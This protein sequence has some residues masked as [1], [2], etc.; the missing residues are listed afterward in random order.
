MGTQNM[1]SMEDQSVS[2]VDIILDKTNLKRVDKTKFLG[3][4][5]D[6]NFSWKNHIDCI[7]K[8]I[9]RNIGMIDKLKFATPERILRTLY[10]TLVLPYINYGI[11]IWG[12]ACKT[13]LEKIHKLQKWA[14]R[15]LSNSYYHSH[16]APLFQKHDILDVYVSYKLEL[17]VFMYF[18]DLLS[19]SFNAFFTQLSDF[20][21]MTQETNLITIQLELKGFC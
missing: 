14:V 21:I 1:T 15:L 13:Y 16:S 18:N 7:T 11:P 19:M 12:K 3:V 6:K 5:I 9:S 10:C 17:G 8:T 4:T 20:H 2:I